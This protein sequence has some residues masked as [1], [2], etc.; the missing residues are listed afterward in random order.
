MHLCIRNPKTKILSYECVSMELRSTEE[1][2]MSRSIVFFTEESNTH[3]QM[4]SYFIVN[5]DVNMLVG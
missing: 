1:Q 5:E 2:N 3:K 4:P